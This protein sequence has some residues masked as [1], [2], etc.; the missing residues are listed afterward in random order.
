MRRPILLALILILLLTVPVPILADAPVRVR[1]TPAPSGSF[2][3]GAD[4]VFAASADGRC[5]LM[6]SGNVLYI[7]DQAE[8]RQIPV[9][10]AAQSEVFHENV[11]FLAEL[12]YRDR[13]STLLPDKGMDD[14][15]AWMDSFDTRSASVLAK[16]GVDRFESFEQ[17]AE[18]FPDRDFEF[19]LLGADDRYALMGCCLNRFVVDMVTGSASVPAEPVGDTL[20]FLCSGRILNMN[21]YM[22]Q[23]SEWDPVTGILRPLLPLPEYGFMMQAVCSGSSGLWLVGCDLPAADNDSSVCALNLVS[24]DPGGKTL[25]VPSPFD[26]ASTAFTVLS[27]MDSAMLSGDGQFMLIYGSVWKSYPPSACVMVDLHSGSAY[28]FWDISGRQL[29]LEGECM[30]PV[31]AAYSGFICYDAAGSQLVCLD[32]ATRRITVPEAQT[33]PFSLAD[34]IRRNTFFG[35]RGNGSGMIFTAIPGYLTVE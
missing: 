27:A 4:R 21:P 29:P 14:F 5:L 18:V 20:T 22:G 1:Y 3:G 34:A 16:Y 15:L 35:A 26:S 7:W 19:C 8:S 9:S 32:A 17:V 23:L 33:L 13:R 10:F 11:R 6:G 2:A 30:K 25:R 31:A 24:L 28:W 12:E